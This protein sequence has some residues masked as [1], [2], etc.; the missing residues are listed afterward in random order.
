[1]FSEKARRQGVKIGGLALL[2]LAWALAGCRERV[3][4][5]T[6]PIEEPSAAGSSGTDGGSAREPSLG[7][8]AAAESDDD[9][10]DDDVG[11]DGDGPVDDDTTDD[12]TPDDDTESADD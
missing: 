2:A 12:D 6:E 5:G 10:E 4:V 7:A 1:M 8:D 3:V 11:N 9:G